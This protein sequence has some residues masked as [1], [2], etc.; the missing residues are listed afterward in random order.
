MTAPVAPLH[1]GDQVVERFEGTRR[2]LT[3]RQADAVDKLVQ[4]AAEE[5]EE[6]GYAKM[7]VRSVARRA[8]VAPA[9]A[10]TYFSSKDHLLA[11]VLWRR[12]EALAPVD[13]DPGSSPAQRVERAVADMIPFAGRNPA[14]I[15]ACTVALISPHPEVRH[16]RDRIGA[17]THRRLSAALGPDAD[18]AVVRVLDTL[19]AGALVTAGT[20][21]MSFMDIPRFM[22]DA[23][24]LLVSDESP[25][26]SPGAAPES[27]VAASMST[28][29]TQ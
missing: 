10:Y 21:H 3:H 1:A 28:R 12:T 19:Y 18:P 13:A 9:T 4:A 8:G 20:G 7:T 23:A 15:D 6:V 11:E 17:L 22:A 14:L 26:E 25:F 29:K 2:R 5:T 16:L 27:D 24:S